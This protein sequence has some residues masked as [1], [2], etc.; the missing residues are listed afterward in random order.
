MVD[1]VATGK[2]LAELFTELNSCKY[3]FLRELN[4]P[5]I[6][7]LRLVVEEGKLSPA[8]SSFKIGG[9]VIS[10][11]YDV[12]SGERTSRFEIAWDHYIAYSVMKEMYAVPD[13]SETFELGNLVRVYSESKFLQYVGHTTGSHEQNPSP[14]QHIEIICEW[15]V[16]D[17]IST[18]VPT[19]KNLRSGAQ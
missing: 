11:G 12:L 15:H 2:S 19:V 10:G 7:S 6:N 1:L 9:V 18:A 16:I 14:W 13:K 3:L 8:S 17:V 5:K 4:E